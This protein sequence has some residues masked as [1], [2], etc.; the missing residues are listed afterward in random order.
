MASSSSHLA[1]LSF[2]HDGRKYVSN[3]KR[4]IS[5]SNLRKVVHA[6]FNKFP[7]I[8]SLVILFVQTELSYEGLWLVS[9][10]FGS[11]R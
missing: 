9:E 2:R 11:V 8:Y 4:R 6:E 7:S 10:R 1:S 3:K 5:S